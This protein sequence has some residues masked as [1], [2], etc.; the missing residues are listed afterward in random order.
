M[1]SKTELLKELGFSPELLT[2]IEQFQG[3]NSIA[4]SGTNLFE[5]FEASQNSGVTSLVIEESEVPCNFEAVFS[6]KR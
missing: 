3:D 4:A 5:S 2:E 1:N 6:F